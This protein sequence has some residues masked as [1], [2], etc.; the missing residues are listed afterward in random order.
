[1]GESRDLPR[2][3]PSPSGGSIASRRFCAAAAIPARRV[4]GALQGRRRAKL[5]QLEPAKAAD[6]APNDPSCFE[7]LREA[8]LWFRI[9]P[10]RFP[11]A[12]RGCIPRQGASINR[13]RAMPSGGRFELPARW[14]RAR[15]ETQSGLHP[16][17]P[18]EQAD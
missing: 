10:N 9:R 1:M 15:F 3:R 11:A 7:L 14:T 6:F 17:P 8:V 16:N 5:T 18:K 13:S 4:N 12:A 2:A